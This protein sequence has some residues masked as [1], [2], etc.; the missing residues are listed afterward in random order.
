LDKVVFLTIGNTSI[1]HFPGTSPFFF[2]AGLAIDA[3][4]SPNAY[5]P[6][7]KVLDALAN[8]GYP[9][10]WW[11]LVT[12]NGKPT[13]T[14]ILQRQTDPSPGLYVSTTALADPS[15]PSAN[16]KRY[17][18]SETVPYIVLPGHRQA[19]LSPKL[20]LG[21]IALVANGKNGAFAYA[22]YADIGPQDQIGEGSIALAEA[23]GVGS[24]PK[25]GN[26][27][28]DIIYVVFPGTGNGR[29]RTPTEIQGTGRTAFQAW[30]AF[31]R[32]AQCFPEYANTLT[33]D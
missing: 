32:L 19:Q 3:D 14:P 27:A 12:D 22:I 1:Y 10:N 13:G 18:D 26:G 28:S 5:G 24:D 23:L 6:H 9:G 31:K 30:G 8:A 4:G 2:K 33:R 29:P 11:A 16:P 15:L 17:V 20:R 25:R 21:D 7:G